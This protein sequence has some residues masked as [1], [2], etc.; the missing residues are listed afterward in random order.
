MESSNPEFPEPGSLAWTA[1]ASKV[2]IRTSCTKPWIVEVDPGDPNAF[3]LAAVLRGGGLGQEG[4]IGISL[5]C[6]AEEGIAIGCVHGC[7]G[8]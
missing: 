1:P 3:I 7:V 2:T 8:L 6:A 5:R 4:I